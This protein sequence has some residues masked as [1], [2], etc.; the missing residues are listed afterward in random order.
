MV[1]VNC[2][3]HNNLVVLQ[4]QCLEPSYIYI[5][6][7]LQETNQMYCQIQC[8]YTCGS[9]QPYK[10]VI[11]CAGNWGAINNQGG[12]NHMYTVHSVIITQCN[13]TQGGRNHMY[14]LYTV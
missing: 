12:Q 6:C 5:Q 8:V 13:N 14:T 11:T 1:G 3:L 4:A 9:G 7:F 2:E 10:S